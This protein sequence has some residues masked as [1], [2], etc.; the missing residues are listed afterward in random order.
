MAI[1]AERYVQALLNTSKDNEQSIMFEKG[2]KGIAD[3]FTSNQEFKNLLLNPCVS[4]EEKI[5]AIKAIFPEYC[6]NDTFVNF[7]RELM[8]KKRIGIIESVSDEYS[9]I[10]RSLNGEL[11]IKIIVASAID[12]NQINDIVNKY[13]ELYNANTIK[14][15]IEI[16]ESVIGGVKVVIGNKIY[17][18]T[19]ETQLKQIF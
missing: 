3:L 5:E 18:S 8:N 11:T 13:K 4:N 16:D 19:L 17:D 10:N 12:E 14:Y 7:L 2:L 1:V 6:K 9:R 15:T